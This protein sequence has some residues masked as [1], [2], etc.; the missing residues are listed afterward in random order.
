MTAPD[1]A[2]V[3]IGTIGEIAA[4]LAAAEHCCDQP[5]LSADTRRMVMRDWRDHARRLLGTDAAALRARPA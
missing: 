4:T 3:G 2:K 1:L 5:F